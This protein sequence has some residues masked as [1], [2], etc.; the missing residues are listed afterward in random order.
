M[1]EEVFK[2]NN[3]KLTKQRKEVYELLK[4]PQTVKD[5]INKKINI[6]PS[7]IYRIIEIFLKTNLIEEEL[8]DNQIY[9][10]I[11]NDEHVHYIKC[12]KCHK[13]EK[14]NLCT[15]KKIK[16]FEIID[17]KIELNGICEKCKKSKN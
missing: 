5:I 17:H 6:N 8:F 11:K 1:V 3:I 2:K 10:K 14:L 4:E 15:I 13:K 12:I 16:G 9:Y 7:T